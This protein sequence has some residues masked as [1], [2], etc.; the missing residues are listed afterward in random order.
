MH[1]CQMIAPQE[2]ANPRGD[3]C[4]EPPL[5][6]GLLA[7]LAG[8]LDEPVDECRLVDVDVRLGACGEWKTKLVAHYPGDRV[9]QLGLAR[10]L[11][12]RRRLTAEPNLVFTVRARRAPRRPR[13]GQRRESRRDPGPTGEGHGR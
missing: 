13:Q 4:G 8:D 12:E 11:A 1:L 5:V 2:K 10:T 9:D 6:P 3:A 7:F